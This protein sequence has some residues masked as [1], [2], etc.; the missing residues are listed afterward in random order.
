M[1]ARMTHG[2]KR[3]MTYF[4]GFLI[5]V[6][7]LGLATSHNPQSAVPESYPP[8]VPVQALSSAMPMSA[9]AMPML[10]PAMPMSAPA[11]PMA[12]QRG[13]AGTAQLAALVRGSKGPMFNCPIHNRVWP[14]NEVHPHYRCLIGNC[15]L[16]RVP[17]L[18][19][20]EQVNQ[21]AP[22]TAPAMPMLSPAMPMSAPWA[23]APA[24][25][26][27]KAPIAAANQVFSQGLRGPCPPVTA[28]PAAAPTPQEASSQI[29]MLPFQ[30]AHWQGLELI[31]LTRGLGR[32]MKIPHE[33]KG[34]IVDDVTGPADMEGFQAGDLITSVGQIPTPTLESFIKA[35]DRVRDRRRT[36]LRLLRKDQPHSLVLTSIR[37][38][39]GTANGETAPMIKP[40]SRPP[41]G[42]KGPC[43]LCH[44]IGTKGQLAVDQGD[45]L[46]REAPSIRADQ[47]PPHRNRGVC[48][49]CHEIIH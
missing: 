11:M 19:Q 36:E 32:I 44:H 43:T 33:A 24:P 35:T 30:E 17:S 5:I 10:S 23:T 4:L 27:L 20:A 12:A 1:N 2:A 45:L 13:N 25:P 34:V 29:K 15:P 9:P 39:L 42:Y 21:L 16:S 3:L 46:T 8:I 26:Q 6:V 28:L 41:H 40:G 18:P 22:M 38:R 14:Q 31:P 48:T 37:D 47:A 7:G 49:A